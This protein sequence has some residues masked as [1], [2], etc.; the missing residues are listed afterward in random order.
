MSKIKILSE[1]LANQ[2]AAGEVIERPA[3][4]IK[5]FLENAIDAEASQ[6]TVQV[7]GGG[8]SL[9]RVIDNGSGMDQDDVLLCLE[10]HATSKL[11]ENKDSG[12]QLDSIR[13]LGFRGEAIPSI[14]SVS[15]LTITS[16]TGDAAL[17]AQVDVRYGKIIK[18]HETGCQRGTVM[19]MRNLFG[20]QPA[21]EKFLKSVR[22]ELSHIEEIVKSYGLANHQLGLTYSVDGTTVINLPPSSDDLETR[23]KRLYKIHKQAAL[24][25]MGS[26][27]GGHTKNIPAADLHLNGFLL[28]PEDSPAAS[29]FRLF[30]NG[31]LV[32]DRMITHAV[33]KGMSG[34]LM[35]GRSPAGVLFITLPTSDVDVNVHPT[36]QEIRF[37]QPEIV[38]QLVVTTVRQAFE[39]Y[40]QRV[41]H[42]L[43][44]T[45]PARSKTEM[46]RGAAGRPPLSHFQ[47]RGPRQ[48]PG[49]ASHEPPSI[50]N[51]EEETCRPRFTSTVPSTPTNHQESLLRQAPFT[52]AE[53]NTFSGNRSN[54]TAIG[55]LLD[56]Y[57]LCESDGRLIVIDQHA[58]HERLLFESLKKQFD[59]KKIARQTLLFPTVLELSP[60]QTQNF[61]SHRREIADFGIEVEEF[62]GGSYVIK[63]VPAVIAHLQPEEI[64][65]DILAQLDSARG[66]HQSSPGPVTSNLDKILSGMACKAAIKSGRPLEDAEIDRLLQDMQRADVFSHCP[67]GR[68]V[69]KIFNADDIKKWF[70]RT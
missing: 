66:G 43:F 39:D 1:H 3:S 41:R 10:R 54:L 46:T 2:I 18:V 67:H 22:T 24:I 61:E 14:A 70:N 56:L 21:R 51:A 58:A 12:R 35:K 59:E 40:Q 65:A 26:S 42:S 9:I 55:Q 36:K 64:L 23:V 44:G 52:K 6:I 28:P 63:S 48:P 13:T 50:F 11:V 27:P 45:P 7:E 37:R 16:R 57:I 32:R 29:I 33:A 20:N 31:R 53:D 38:H 60:L 17:G 5:E 8:S 25:P 4:V 15:K 47:D 62:G 19:E 68:P 34:F 30:V 49:F 69:A